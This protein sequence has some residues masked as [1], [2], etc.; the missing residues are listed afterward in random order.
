MAN[1]IRTVIQFRRDLS[2]NWLQHKDI[3]PAAGEPCFETD[4]GVFKIG[5]GKTAYEHLPVIGGAN[6]EV[7]ADGK[8]IVLEDGVFK[9][10]GF[11]AAEV[12]AQPRKNADGNIEW[13]VPST[14]TVEGLQSAVA[15]LQSDVTTL[16]TTVVNIQEIVTPSGEDSVPLLTR[17]EGL[18]TKMDG[19]GE[20]TVDA[21]IDA[22]INEFAAKV[23]DDGNVNTLKELVDYVA[24]HGNAAADMA[25]DITTLN[26]LVGETPVSEQ[27]I[28]AI[29]G[30]GHVEKAE[31]EEI[32]K[33]VKYE[34]SH[35]PVGTLVNYSDKEIR[36][37]VP[38][39]T[40]F[41]HQNS[42]ENADK[43]QYYIGFKAYAPEGAVS[44]KEDLAEIISDNTMYYFEGN[45][46]AGIDAYGR[47]YSICWLAVA[48]YDEATQTWIRYA[49]QSSK[50]KYLGYYYSVEWYDTDGVKIDSDCIRINLSN[51][52]CHN[53]VEPY[54]MAG[55]VKKVA[56]NGTLLDVVDGKVD[57]KVDNIIKDSDEIVVNEDGSLSINTISMD[58]LTQGAGN[59]VLDG[60]SAVG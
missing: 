25:A 52:S 13:V 34:I 58:K 12:G 49:D 56:V 54:Y 7:S 10:M 57:I 44:F 24:T 31:A 20:G 51:E 1:I 21:K 60:G 33:H 38:A 55:V 19:T 41:E 59:L 26:K 28:T 45:D 2:E 53:I 32:Y 5:D 14:E 40:K 43:N 47:K 18:E 23:S 3:V 11:D 48:Y 16:Q 29:E 17:V 22:K 35:K 4:T 30:S 46:F 27:I 15:G 42:G 39:G 36:I 37:M 8:S 6:V 9:L 50:E